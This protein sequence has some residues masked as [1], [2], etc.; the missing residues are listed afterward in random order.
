[1]Q[2]LTSTSVL[3]LTQHNLIFAQLSLS[4]FTLFPI[5][6]IIN[7]IINNVSFDLCESL[8]WCGKRHHIV[9]QLLY[10][11]IE[12]ISGAGCSRLKANVL[13]ELRSYQR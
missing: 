11:L 4:L 7:Q 8:Y 10:K 6:T 2:L 1:M 12:Q 13:R 3:T 9:V 5:L